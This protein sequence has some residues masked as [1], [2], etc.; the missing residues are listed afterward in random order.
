MLI[1]IPVLG[2]LPGQPALEHGTTGKLSS[3][4]LATLFLI[5]EKLYCS[6]LH[7]VLVKFNEQRS[8]LPSNYP[9]LIRAGVQRHFGDCPVF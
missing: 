3:P 8:T 7:N 1:Q 5:Y 9:C 6:R 2:V 4:E